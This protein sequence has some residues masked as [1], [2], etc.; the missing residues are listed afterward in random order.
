M[1]DP[2]F[3]KSDFWGMGKKIDKIKEAIIGDL[4]ASGLYSPCLNIQIESLAGA[5]LTLRIANA[6][7]EKLKTS[8]A[9]EKSKYGEKPVPDPAFRIQRDAMA[10]VSK[11]MKQLNLTV[12]DIVGRPEVPGPIDELT[13]KL[14]ALE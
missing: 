5:V 7:I 1:R 8:R 11:Q 10:E 9:V 14:D 4:R 2:I 13:A 3:E 6:D 12:L